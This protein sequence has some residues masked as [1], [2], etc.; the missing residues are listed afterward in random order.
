MVRLERCFETEVPTGWE[1][2]CVVLSDLCAGWLWTFTPF[3]VCAIIYLSSLAVNAFFL[4]R[5]VFPAFD[6]HGPQT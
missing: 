5:F 4:F 3:V 1:E 6:T 2:S